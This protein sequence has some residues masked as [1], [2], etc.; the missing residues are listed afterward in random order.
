VTHAPG[1]TPTLGIIAMQPIYQ[2]IRTR[3]R[4]IAE[5]FPAPDFYFDHAEANAL[6]LR[7]LQQNPEMLRLEKIVSA[8]LEDNFGHGFKHSRKVT[9]DAGAL[10]I[11]EGRQAGHPEKAVHHNVMLAHMAGMLHD[12]KRKE[13]DHAVAGAVFSREVLQDFPLSAQEQ[14]DIS[15]AIRNH[16]AFKKGIPIKRPDGILIA[17]CLYDADKFRWG[18]DNFTDTVWDMVA[19]HNPPLSQFIKYYPEGMQGIEKIKK[20]FRTA[21]GKVYGPQFIELGIAIGNRLYKT[22]LTEF[23]SDLAS[24][25]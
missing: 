6:S 14:D 25:M 7:L 13:K 23:K 19:F 21:T 22:I 12:V 4:Q 2:R 11:I 24:N 8:H 16:E 18:P 17:G 20:T 5:T 9:L 1:F 15:I 10:M 3:A